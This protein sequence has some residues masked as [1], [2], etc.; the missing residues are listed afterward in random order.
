MNYNKGVIILIFAI[1][2][3][4]QFTP[5]I[6]SIYQEKQ[7]FKSNEIH[8]CSEYVEVAKRNDERKTAEWFDDH[9]NHTDSIWDAVD[10]VCEGGTIFVHKGKYYIDAVSIDLYKSLTIKGENKY[11]TIFNTSGSATQII[12]IKK[13]QTTV[14]NL[15]IE[16]CKYRY[17]DSSIQ[18][19]IRIIFNT[20][21]KCGI[22]I[23]NN[24]IRNN[25]NGIYINSLTSD[26]SYIIIQNNT[27]HNN[28]RDGIIV[29]SN[30]TRIY[31]NKITDNGQGGIDVWGKQH[32]FIKGNELVNNLDGIWLDV[33]CNNLIEK[34]LIKNNRRNGISI[35]DYEHPDY[36]RF[37]N[38]NKIVNNS[39]A[40][41][42][43]HGIY[44]Y[45]AKGNDIY[46]NTFEF[47]KNSNIKIEHY[48]T[49]RDFFD[50]RQ[51]SKYNN[52]R[53][54]YMIVFC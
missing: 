16:G 45:H 44:L 10:L 41:N 50:N 42:Q 54:L 2:L 15:T 6:S 13:P 36:I 7:L 19:G 49:I 48:I 8:K 12:Q 43:N 29:G 31:N 39:F 47:N 9:I 4:A 32:T 40:Q 37:C 1:F 5:T 35:Y 46:H 14:S 38:C 34:N 51:H 22:T 21:D 11:N 24:I 53:Y 17:D 28:H 26:H 23:E 52:I 30:Y 18:A 25:A 27:I 20:N 3:V 33:T